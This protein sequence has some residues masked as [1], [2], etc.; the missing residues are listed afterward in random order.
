MVMRLFELI[1]SNVSIFNPA[2]VKLSIVWVFEYVSIVVLDIVFS[3]R[4][5]IGIEK[6]MMRKNVYFIALL[7]IESAFRS[8]VVQRGLIPLN[9]K[10]TIAA[11]LMVIKFMIIKSNALRLKSNAT[12]PEKYKASN[13]PAVDAGGRKAAATA[14]PTR[15]SSN[16]EVNAKAAAIPAANAMLMSINVGFVRVKI[17]LVIVAHG[18]KRVTIIEKNITV[19]SPKIIPTTLFLNKSKSPTFMLNAAEIIG[20]RN[21]ETIIEPTTTAVLFAINPSVASIPARKQRSR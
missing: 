7:K 12:C 9:Q 16:F 14:T 21:G 17:S 5:V 2:L 13:I 18:K 1:N 10:I 6:I 11:K 8:L 3:V 19:V 15:L 20:L 4:Y